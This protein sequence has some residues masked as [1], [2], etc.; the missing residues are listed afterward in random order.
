ML[1]A[2]KGI[3]QFHQHWGIRAGATEVDVPMFVFVLAAVDAGE[4][5]GVGPGES[6]CRPLLLAEILC[7]KLALGALG[8]LDRVDAVRSPRLA[9]S[10]QTVLIGARFHR[11]LDKVPAIRPKGLSEVRKAED[12]DVRSPQRLLRL[13]QAELSGTSSKS[14]HSFPPIFQLLFLLHHAIPSNLKCDLLADVLEI[15]GLDRRRPKVPL[16]AISEVQDPSEFPAGLLKVPQC[17]RPPCDRLQQKIHCR[18]KLR[19][20]A[21]DVCGLL[22]LDVELL[23]GAPKDFRKLHPREDN[24]ILEPCQAQLLHD[25]PLPC[26]QRLRGV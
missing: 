3:L 24:E 16:L 19:V 14:S 7:R 15:Q 17:T 25:V 21:A 1:H 12:R 23:P 26:A 18:R 2:P 20:R 10:P 22:L 9:G 4:G 6:G 11:G 13:R 5:G 8:T